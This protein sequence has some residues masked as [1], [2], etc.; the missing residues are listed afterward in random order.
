MTKNQKLLHALSKGKA[1]TKAKARKNWDIMNL[2]A[3]VCRLRQNGYPVHLRSR[4]SGTIEYVLGEPT[5][6]I[7]ALGYRARAMG[8]PSFTP[9]P[10]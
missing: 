2:K 8:I 10:E 6:D 3:E 1:I 9:S 7:I 5:R 4:A